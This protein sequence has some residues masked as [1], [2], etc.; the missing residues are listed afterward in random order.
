MRP[1][2]LLLFGHCLVGG[3]GDAHAELG[4]DAWLEV[5]FVSRVWHA[6]KLAAWVRQAQL[7]D[8]ARDVVCGG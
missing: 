8:L 1:G 5:S 2:D 7:D 4:V 6:D 3:H